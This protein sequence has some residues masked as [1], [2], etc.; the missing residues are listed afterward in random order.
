MKLHRKELL[1]DRLKDKVKKGGDWQ[2]WGAGDNVEMMNGIEDG[3]AWG[4]LLSVYWI[5]YRVFLVCLL[6][7][8]Y[9]VSCH[10]FVLF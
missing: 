6:A 1:C 7:L 4:F 9:L 3:S 10:C 5:L 2:G 8:R